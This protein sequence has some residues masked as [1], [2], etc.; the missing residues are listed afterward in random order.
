M[1]VA[2]LPRAAL[3]VLA[4]L[5]A[6]TVSALPASAAPALTPTRADEW[7]I[8]ALNVPAA[9]RAAPPAGKGVTVAVLSTG[10]DASH[11]DLAGSVL[12]GPDYSKTGRSA[13]SPYWGAEG[14]AVASLIA[15]HG[16]GID[17]DQGITGVAPHARILSV[18]VTQEYD[19]PQVSDAAVMARLPDAIA[20]GI[21]YAVGHGAAVIAL[22]LDPGMLG[23]TA[24]AD[25]AAANG[26]AAERSAVS[27]AL[28]HGVLLVAPAGDNG[29][30]G[31]AANYP[32]AY[33]GVV[34]VG[35]TARDAS[36]SLF[37]SKDSYVTVTAPGSGVTP[38]SPQPFGPLTDPASG[39]T[40]AAPE[41]GY[42]SLASTDM[43][44]AL[45]AGVAA[46]I[47]SSYP[48]LTVPEVTQALEQ[49]SAVPAT[50][51]QQAASASSG[52]AGWGHGELDAAAALAA[53][54]VIAAA[55]PAAHPASVPS[56]APASG[57]AGQP[58]PSKPRS[59]THPQ[60]RASAADPGKVLRNLLIDLVI[61]AGALILGLIALMSI[62][63]L[64]R[65]P[66]AEV[67]PAHEAQAA[68]AGTHARRPRAARPAEPA[69]PAG[70]AGPAE[71]DRPGRPTWPARPGPATANRS[72]S[73]AS[74][75]GASAAGRS[76]ARSATGA[77][78]SW[79]DSA[80][81]TRSGS[82]WPD[83]VA[84]PGWTA[85]A[86]GLGS[87]APDL[88]YGA[89]VGAPAGGDAPWSDATHVP[90]AWPADATEQPPWGRAVPRDAA[91]A[92]PEPTPPWEQRKNTWGEPPTTWGKP[93]NFIPAPLPQEPSPRPANTGPM[94]VWNP[95]TTSPPRK[96]DE[97]QNQ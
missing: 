90:S 46:L 23:A 67:R 17:D 55:H 39:L 50:A 79:S 94:Y 41:N 24:D 51:R 61:A 62:L 18:Q 40:V 2:R 73:G 27:F 33:P 8:S 74:R 59:R 64:R 75:F 56:A 32:A 31:D 9:W 37:T 26:S 48:W 10:V 42:D 92:A 54:K 82:A 47:R 12:T 29:A 4:A 83:T 71:P 20:A 72:T 70:P 19:D 53:A 49:G 97:D 38:A 81:S 11:P 95:A 16:H 88:G 91:P 69:G 58:A 85:P 80:W 66:S 6:L 35:A 89:A 14:T 57:A 87:H 52:L 44:A 77:T 13:G 7:W 60:V 25:P 76:T 93:E 1:N 34:A 68:Y 86:A 21:R 36:L 63:R 96:T 43:A 3:P 22:P 28:A 78:P 30:A 5:A 45:T 84:V 15:G 65:R